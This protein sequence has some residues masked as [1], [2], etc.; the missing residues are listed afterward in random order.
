MS[1]TTTSR[2]SKKT[3][4]TSSSPSITPK[5][6]FPWWIFSLVIFGIICYLCY[7]S[8][9]PAPTGVEVLTKKQS[10]EVKDLFTP[11]ILGEMEHQLAEDQKK[12]LEKILGYEV[13]SIEDLIFLASL[14][15]TLPE[16]ENRDKLMNKLC[17]LIPDLDLCQE[18][19]EF[20]EKSLMNFDMSMRLYNSLNKKDI[21]TLRRILIYSPKELKGSK[22]I[23]PET[24]KQ[25]RSLLEELGGRSCIQTKNWMEELDKVLDEL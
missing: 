12:K 16:G 20:L 13:I 10:E 19:C 9:T 3:E 25:L 2:S 4:A 7:H 18:G 21:K 6:Q 23:G 17:T 8:R 24:L 22:G 11:Q 5:A 1:T 14:V 15:K